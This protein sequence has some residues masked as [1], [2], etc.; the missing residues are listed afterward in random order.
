MIAEPAFLSEYT[1]FALDRTKR[2][3]AAHIASVKPEAQTIAQKLQLRV[4]SMESLFRSPS[5]ESLFRSPS[6]ESLFRSPSKESLNRL[7]DPES[8]T[9]PMYDPASDIESEAEDTMGSTDSLSKEQLHHRLRRMERSLSIYRGKYSELVTAYRTVQRDKEKVQE[10]QMDQQ[11]KKHIQEEFDAAL[12]EKDQHIT[13]LQTQAILSQCQDKSLRR[14]GELREELQM[15]QQAKK[16]IQEEFDAAL[17]E[18]DQHIT[19]LQTQVALLKQRLH[20]GQGNA[21]QT[22]LTTAERQEVESE[23]QSSTQE[24]GTQNANLSEDGNGDASK[25]LEALQQR[26][27]RQE[28]LLQK[29]KEMLRTHKERSTQLGS[30]KETLQEQLEE[31]L[32]ELEKIK[33]LHTAEKTKLITQL[34]DAKNLIEQLEQD[35]GMVIA[36]TKRQMHETLEMK[37][38]EIAQLRS[39]I[40]QTTALRE[41]LQEQKEKSEK[42]AFEEL[43]KTLST[44]QKAEEARRQ[45]KAQMEE[46][47]KA[48]EKASEEER[49]NLQQE[50]SRVKQEVVNIMK[51]SSEDRIAEVEKMHAEALASKDQEL[52]QRLQTREAELL[53]QMSMALE[54]CQAENTLMIQEKEQ[55]AALALEELELQKVAIQSQN[56]NRVQELQEELETF[57]TKVLE[58]ESLLAK[59]SQRETDKSD[60]LLAQID[61]EKNRH[62]AE[63][64]AMDEKHKVEMDRIRQELWELWSDKL[65]TTK[66][67]YQTSMDELQEKHTQ[68]LE[69]LLKEKESQFHSHIKDMNQKTLEK[70]DVKQT[71]LETLSSEL[72]EALKGRKLLEEH[73][74]ALNDT[75]ETIKEECEIKVEQEKARYLGEVE[76]IKSQ[77]K[78]SLEGVE[79]TLKEELNNLKMVLE[80]KEKQL[81]ELQARERELKEEAE[82]HQQETAA[83]FELQMEELRENVKRAEA[84]KEGLTETSSKLNQVTSELENCQ[85]Q[86]QQLE[87]KLKEVQKESDEKVSFLQAEHATKIAELQSHIEKVEKE[88]SESEQSLTEKLEVHLQQEKDLNKQLEEVRTA[89]EQRI[90]AARTQY[91]TKLKANEAKMDKLKQKA[92]EMQEKFKKKLSDQE[93]KLKEQ[94]DKKQQELNQ[95]EKEFNEKILEMAHAGSAGI[96]DAVSQLESTQKEQLESLKKSHQKELEELIQGWQRK[97]SQQEEEMQE[98][99]EVELQEKVDDVR[100]QLGATREEKEH[101]LKEV[102]GLREELV[103]RETT[104]Q[105]LQA[106]L[107]EAAAQVENLSKGETMLKEQVEAMEKNFSQVLNERNSLQNQL[108]KAEEDSNK[109]EQELAKQLEEACGK[110]TALEA[111]HCKEGEALQKRLEEKVLEMQSKEEEFRKQLNQLTEHVSLSCNEVQRKMEVTADEFCDQLNSKVSALSDRIVCN[112]EQAAQ[113]KNVILTKIERISHLEVQLQ[114]ITEEKMVLENSLLQ[115]TNQMQRKEEHIKV[116][117]TEKESLEKDRGCHL[118]SL[119]EKDM[120]IEQ[121][122]KELTASTETNINVSENLKEKEAQ[123]SSLEGMINDLKTQLASS[124]G[125]AEKEEAI[126]LI[127]QQHKEEHQKLINQMQELSKSME[128]LNQEKSSALD[129]AEQWKSKLSDWKKKA[130]SKFTLNHNTIK[131][132]QG[133]LEEMEKQIDEKDEQLGKLTDDI[134]KQSRSKSEMDQMLS[135]KEKKVGELTTELQNSIFKIRELEEQLVKKTEEHDHLIVQ[136]QQMNQAKDIEQKELVLQLQQAKVQFSEK[137]NRVKETEEKLQS[138]ERETE[139]LKQELQLK[140]EGFEKVKAEILKS[141]EEELKAE[142]ERWSAESAGKLAELKKKAE[143]KIAMVRKQLTSQVE[144]KEQIVKNLESQLDELKQVVDKKEESVKTLEQRVNSLEDSASREEMEKQIKNLREARELEKESTLQNLKEMYEEKLNVL[145]KDLAD[146]DLQVQMMQERETEKRATEEEAQH[147]H[148]E[149]QNNLEQ[150]EE[151]KRK[152][153]AEVFRLREELQKQAELHSALLDD[154]TECTAT[155]SDLQKQLLDNEGKIQEM[156]SSLEQMKKN[157]Q[158]RESSE[159]SLEQKIKELESSLA[160]DKENFKVEKDS[161]SEQ[162][163]GELKDLRRQLEE[164]GSLLRDYEEGSE[165]KTKSDSEL[166]SLLAEMRAKQKELD[167][168]LQEADGEKQKLHKEMIRLQ[169]DIRSLRKEHEKELDYVKKEMAEENEQKMKLE[170][171]DLEMKHNSSLKQIIR[172]FN[173]QIAKKD[174]ELDSAVQEAIGKAQEVE[175]ELLNTYREEANQ[176]YKKIGQKE[177]ELKQTAQKYEQMLQNREEEMTCRVNELQKELEELQMEKQQRLNDEKNQN[178]EQ[179]SMAEL[180]AQLALKTT[181]LSEA[182]L[183]EQEFQERIHSLE[184]KLRTSPKNSVV[185]HLGTPN[186]GGN[187]HSDDLSEPT[188][189]EYLRKVMF[190]YM[191]GRETK[192]MAKVLTT[193]LKFP[194]DQAQKILEKEE[195]RPLIKNFRT[196]IHQSGSS[197]SEHDVLVPG[198]NSFKMAEMV[199]KGR[200]DALKVFV[201]L[202]SVSLVYSYNIDLDHPVV[203]QGPKG[204]FFGYSVLEHYHGNTRWVIVGAPKANSTFSVSVSSPG[205]IFKCRV[206]NNPEKMCTEM[207]MGRG[208]ERSS[209]CGKTCRGDRE[210]EWMGVSLARQDRANGSVLACAHRWKNVFYESEHILPHGF[211]SIIPPNLQ[212]NRRDLIPCYEEYKKKYGEEHGSCQAGI[213]GFFTEMGSYF[214]SSL[215]AVDLNQDGLSDLLVGAPMFSEIRDEGHVAV[216]I[217]KG[218]M[219]SYFGSSL[220]AVD[221]NQD[222][223]SDLLVG[224]PMF[225]EIR[226]EGHVAVFINK[227]NGVL[228]ERVLLNG[229]NAYNAHFGESIAMLGDIDDDGFPDVA[230]GAPKE[231]DFAGA[232]YIYHG[233]A[234]GIVATY[235]MRLSGQNINPVLRMFG[236]SIS[237]NVDM[238]GN[239]YPDVTIGAFMSDNVV[240]L[241]ARPVITVDILIFLPVSINITAPQ[242]HDGSQH[243]NCLN[244]SACL[245]FRGKQVPGQIGL[246]YNLTADVTKREKGQQSRVVFALNGELTSQVNEQIQLS[247]NEEK[248]QHYMAYVR[249]TGGELVKSTLVGYGSGKGTVLKTRFAQAD[250]PADHLGPAVPPDSTAAS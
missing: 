126:L 159:K 140:Q 98:K 84:E 90:D 149:L 239:A 120:C 197:T 182:K 28:N 201:A 56:E 105:K 234:H 103:M 148:K 51:K 117:K 209:S 244:V 200:R 212:R 27:R 33:E 15:D 246:L 40:L 75:I 156:E 184:D 150:A 59:S 250:T 176:L 152:H 20:S 203:Y 111:A 48:V 119:S 35:K 67:Q 99:H 247:Y 245:H 46:R 139:T 52:T 107:R 210:N 3:K 216:F 138:I 185:T 157:I 195:S 114:Q 142:E 16:H 204:S 77:F 122:R 248:C 118:E 225:S 5:K 187:Y 47:I 37:E 11:A 1:I 172:E 213:A 192:T 237:G 19:V 243:L 4:P 161:L 92:R 199:S 24:L 198:M 29:C 115:M 228:E 194:A 43:E 214:G 76:G 160:K 13:V 58:L 45:L 131:S 143:Q 147:R 229:D 133:K 97:L 74:A 96:S 151:D 17:E 241:R 167:G 220:C 41:E 181:L 190:E 50:L 163:E 233:D 171:E 162:Y 83:K 12:E 68:E 224:A 82:K 64:A 109:R 94:C 34:R 72:T 106:E 14:I 183:K 60:E 217:N 165:Q 235:S 86:V 113:L 70:L 54:K 9:T 57:S 124:V 25:T 219:G 207:D 32:Q 196:F 238:D 49:K 191:M 153:Q 95:K 218:N 81:E 130:E 232:V 240:L 61:A 215:C 205:A 169:K 137:C 170:L 186:R 69:A 222:G 8:A 154:H 211:C 145:Q 158:E 100:Q 63:I 202:F 230:I 112:Q 21:D 110:L 36:E 80:E 177:D 18:K 127:N 175:T 227:G 168:K 173:T 7:G 44:A 189:F 128:V 136:L 91:E 87:Q 104:V 179:G 42:D 174:Q 116:F 221:L 88:L 206:H 141:K 2:P 236:Q 249:C 65:Q 242:C 78:Q 132:L 178:S 188:E 73:L 193:V 129:Q 62:Q 79:K 223:L 101:V 22:Q 108:S 71:E 102:K 231:E 66:K 85:C 23:P 123:I 10:L 135:E 208:N 55:Q 26:V 121:L 155:L 39:R 30:E 164:N 89:G 134:D 226:D 31:R 125:F 53:E 144:E 146:R 93:V 6:K 180:Q 38:E 166:Q